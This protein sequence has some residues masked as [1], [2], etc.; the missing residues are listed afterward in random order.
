MSKV[1]KST[2]DNTIARLFSVGV[3]KK[4]VKGERPILIDEAYEYL[5]K[6]GFIEKK[7]T[8]V[9]LYRSAYRYLTSNYRNEYIYKNAIANK[10]LLGTHNLNTSHMLQEF[11]VS[12][13]KADVLILNG[14][15]RVYEI[16]SELDSFDRLERQIE[17]YRKAFDE[18]FV[19]VSE[20][21]KEKALS[22]LP[23]F[24]GIQEFRKSGVIGKPVQEA[25]SN[26]KNVSNDVIYDSLRRKEH[27][28]ILSKY[29]DLPRVPNT[30]AFKTYKDFFKKLSPE[31]A[32][33]EMVK[34]LKRRGEAK[35]L[36]NFIESVPEELVAFA[37][38]AKLLKSERKKFLNLLGQPI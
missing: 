18:I 19:I 27:M 20:G 6:D 5:F 29:Y 38:G 31:I 21:Q 30:E 34:V 24:V 14:T 35:D 2:L 32:H 7:G 8:L 26:K 12:D 23:E 36:K 37:L 3:T 22:C 17:A 16:K 25:R 4:L 15:S 13:C 10:I 1:K 9:E 28:Q 33:D 11:R